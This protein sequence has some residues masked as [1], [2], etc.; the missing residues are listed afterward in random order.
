MRSYQWAT[1]AFTA[2]AVIA[3]YALLFSSA[4]DIGARFGPR[5]QDM[6]ESGPQ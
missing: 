2:L 6:E 3:F 5:L 1:V 4:K